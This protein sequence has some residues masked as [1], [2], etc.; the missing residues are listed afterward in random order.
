MKLTHVLF[1]VVPFAF[2]SGCGELLPQEE[3]SKAQS[4][5][6]AQQ[7]SD[8]DFELE[9]GCFCLPKFS[10]LHVSVKGGHIVEITD[11]QTTEI[12]PHDDVAWVRTIEGYFE[13]LQAEDPSHWS[14]TFDSVLGYPT[15]I[16]LDPSPEHVDDEVTFRLTLNP[17]LPF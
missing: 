13:L 17:L 16:R 12:L 11:K 7:L 9:R 2:L 14:A 15:E 3:R 10:Q 1:V 5:W 8:Y 4:R 6:N